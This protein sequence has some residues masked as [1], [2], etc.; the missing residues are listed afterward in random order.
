MAVDILLYNPDGTE[1]L[2]EVGRF[3]TV[4]SGLQRV[5]DRVGYELLL[6]PGSV[7]GRVAGTGI[8]DAV[9]GSANNL[10]VLAAFSP[11]AQSVLARL[12]VEPAVP[13]ERVVGIYLVDLTASEGV[14][15]LVINV[16][17]ATGQIGTG[18]VA[19]SFPPEA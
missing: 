13:D 11:A 9:Y 18:D 4:S 10:D 16:V 3:G 14:V 7:A 5:V 8:V 17:T 6:E 15:W 12:A 2:P 1:A 19:V